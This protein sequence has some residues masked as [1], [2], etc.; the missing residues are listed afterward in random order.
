MPFNRPIPDSTKTSGGPGGMRSLGEAEKLMQI[1]FLLPSA[2]LVGWGI[3]ALAEG[4]WH[5]KWMIAA[6]LIFGCVAG[7][8]SVIRVAF[9]AERAASKDENASA[10]KDTG[11]GTAQ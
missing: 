10:G 3:G 9:A 1:A 5:Q 11:S 4:H 2:V 6:G 8:V 7:L